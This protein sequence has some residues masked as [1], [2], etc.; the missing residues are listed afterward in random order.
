VRFARWNRFGSV[1]QV[2]YVD[3]GSTTRSESNASSVEVL[4]VDTA[5]SGSR[6]AA[7]VEP[8]ARLT[9][10]EVLGV[11]PGG[12]GP[13]QSASRS[14]FH[15][16]WLCAC[17]RVVRPGE[18]ERAGRWSWEEATKRECGSTLHHRPTT[19]SG[20]GLGWTERLGSILDPMARRAAPQRSG[21]RRQAWRPKGVNRL[22]VNRKSARVCPTPHP[23]MSR[24]FASRCCGLL[25]IVDFPLNGA[26]NCSRDVFLAPGRRTAGHALCMAGCSSAPSQK[27]KSPLMV[28][29]ATP[30]SFAELGLRR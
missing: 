26:F 22:V 5:F 12:R 3:H 21:P 7:E 11:H 17:T 25:L 23:A 14:G 16:D 1:G 20:H 24:S 8:A 19:A 29:G 4:Q 27:P 13:I 28:S 30:V 15:L 9:L 18:H 10:A 6:S 2:P